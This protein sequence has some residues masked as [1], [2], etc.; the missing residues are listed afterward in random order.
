MTSPIDADRRL[1]AFLETGPTELPDRTY[2]V[3]RAE[4]EHTRQRV[5][6]GPWKESSMS[7]Y[8]RVAVA[9]VAVIVA[10]V[11]A[12]QL[13]PK[14]AA[15][16]SPSVAPLPTRVSSFPVSGALEPGRYR[17][18]GTYTARPLTIDVP[19]GWSV[20]ESSFIIKGASSAPIDRVE[21]SVISFSPWIID[22]LFTG[23][24]ATQD[25]LRA[26]DQTR[27]AL[28][29]GLMALPGRAQRAP[30]ETTVDGFPATLVTLTVP[31]DFDF[32]GCDGPRVRNWP[33]PGGG[34]EGGWPSFAGQTD[35]ITVVDAAGDPVVL[36]LS[37]KGGARPSDVDAMRSMTST[38]HFES[39]APASEVPS[40]AS[41]S[42]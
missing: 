28:V 33:D 3:V 21:D 13:L 42:S 25:G 37:F 39:E 10:V 40:S 35:E 36:V 9:V 27:L 17:F 23:G 16:G 26:V 5:V 22:Q 8:A 2:D 1:Q 38:I 14:G 19:G 41:P 6:F 18:A 32:A 31:P 7:R 20:A 29:D 11:G 24:C 30:V 15:V 12:I 4:I 34:A